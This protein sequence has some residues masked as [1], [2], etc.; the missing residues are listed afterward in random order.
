MAKDDTPYINVRL[1]QAVLQHHVFFFAEN[2]YI[3]L[4]PAI[5]DAAVNSP[6]IMHSAIVPFVPRP[7]RSN[8]SKDLLIG[9][10]SMLYTGANVHQHHHAEIER[11]EEE[12]T[13]ML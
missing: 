8:L 1:P 5:S 11:R 13:H 6:A 10:H 2:G 3:G 4:A 9:P 7:L 12:I